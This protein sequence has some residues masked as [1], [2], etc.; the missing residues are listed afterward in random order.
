MDMDEKRLQSVCFSGHRNAEISPA[1]QTIFDIMLYTRVINGCCD[2]Y[3][4]G[5]AGWDAFCS[6]KVIA[7]RNSGL[8]V[9]LH[10]ILPYSFEEYT[11][12]WTKRNRCELLEIKEQAN[13]VEYITEQFTYDC[14]KQRNQR[15]VDSAGWLWCFYDEKRSRSGTGQTVRMAEK[16]GLRIR[17]L[18]I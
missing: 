16:L 17:N 15:L 13:T 8:N 4:G 10:L 7:L 6:K 2:F 5:A 12:R 9:R 1:V 14:I 18:N 11:K 3:A